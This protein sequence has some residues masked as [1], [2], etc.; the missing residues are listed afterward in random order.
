MVVKPIKTRRFR[1][2]RDDLEELL[3]SS[4][5][6][7]GENTVVAVAS[8]IVSI[9]EGRCI[10]RDRVKDKDK[11]IIG[12]ADRYLPRDQVPGRW[13]MHTLK[14]N[15][16]MPSAG[17]DESNANGYYILWPRNPTKSVQKIGQF[18]RKKYRLKNLGVIITDSHS[19][20]LR[21]GVI[22]ISLA[23]WGFE[24]LKGYRGTQDIFGKK[25]VFS[26]TNL[27]DGLAAAAV[28]VMGE[29]QEQTPLA[30]IS[31]LVGI[32]FTS[33]TVRP[34][35]P[36]SSFVVKPPEDMYRPFLYAVKWRKG[37]GGAKSAS[38]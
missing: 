7:L 21:R 5:P 10:P 19:V 1:P 30:V 18:L 4:L 3:V 27:P 8:K 12:E 26:Q 36:F 20:P 14:D 25:L 6:R 22:G 15:I 38:L 24:P 29:G 11:L 31:D 2:P 13:V 9:G 32:K 23:H 28:V 17:I 33:H 37:R 35:G 34:R 16:F